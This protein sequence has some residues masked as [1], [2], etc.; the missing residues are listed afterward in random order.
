MTE[1]S[2]R[3]ERGH[4]EVGG[5][6]ALICPGQLSLEVMNAATRFLSQGEN[7]HCQEWKGVPFLGPHYSAMAKDFSNRGCITVG[8]CSADSLFWGLC[9]LWLGGSLNKS[10]N[11]LT[12]IPRMMLSLPSWE[13]QLSQTGL[14]GLFLLATQLLIT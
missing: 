9:R 1:N 4:P 11:S 6:L 10:P 5:R 13:A 3:G 12:A 8:L 7:T 2:L 14:A